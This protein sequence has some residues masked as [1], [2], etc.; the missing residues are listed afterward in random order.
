M[1]VFVRVCKI[2][3]DCALYKR[4]HMY[5]GLNVCIRAFICVCLLLNAINR[6][7]WN[8]ARCMNACTYACMYVVRLRTYV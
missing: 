4:T 7:G 3:M 6:A 5:E 8:V 2:L 1:N